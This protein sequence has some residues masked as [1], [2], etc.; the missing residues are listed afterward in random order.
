VPRAVKVGAI[1]G[2][3]VANLV[4]EGVPFGIEAFQLYR[5]YKSGQISKRDFMEQ[6]LKTGCECSGGLVG[7]T[8]GGIVGQIVIPAPFLGGVVG[9]LL[10]SLIGRWLMAMAGKAIAKKLL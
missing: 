4:A 8:T 5:K 7:V 9:C 1:A 10:G 2:N 6:L 3:V